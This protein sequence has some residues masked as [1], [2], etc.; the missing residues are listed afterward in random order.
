MSCEA[1]RF[2]MAP[3]LNMANTRKL[4]DKLL[5]LTIQFCLRIISANSPRGIVANDILAGPNQI[6]EGSWP[7]FFHFDCVSDVLRRPS[8]RLL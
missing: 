2:S 7:C 6:R 5:V 1:H 8:H 4:S 3:R